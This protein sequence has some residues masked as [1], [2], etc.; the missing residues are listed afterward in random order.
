MDAGSNFQFASSAFSSTELTSI[1]VLNWVFIESNKLDKLLLRQY[2]GC[3][4]AHVFP[5]LFFRGVLLYLLCQSLII[6]DAIIEATVITVIWGLTPTEVGK[7]LAS[8]TN[9]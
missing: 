7:T 2:I 5:K 6:L 1:S 8:Q 4:T 9:K 3:D